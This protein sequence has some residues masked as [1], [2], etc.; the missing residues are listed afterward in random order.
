MPRNNA[1]LNLRLIPPLIE[2]P[3]G[4]SPSLTSNSTV[5]VHFPPSTLPT[6][7]RHAKLVSIAFVPTFCHTICLQALSATFERGPATRHLVIVAALNPSADT[8]GPRGTLA[9]STAVYE[10]YAW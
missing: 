4:T 3:V 6:Q 1:H 9:W 5:G 8:L 2:H 10:L 7:L